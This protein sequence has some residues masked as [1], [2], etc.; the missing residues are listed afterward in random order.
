M[1]PKASHKGP[2]E[3]LLQTGDVDFSQRAKR[4]SPPAN[5]A[6]ATTECL[7]SP[8]CGVKVGSPVIT[9]NAE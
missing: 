5:P 6:G 7:T 3:P 4:E 1:V 2:P 9:E 8:I